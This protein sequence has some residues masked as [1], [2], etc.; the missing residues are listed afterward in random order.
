M[1]N[2]YRPS[3]NLE[4]VTPYGDLYKRRKIKESNIGPQIAWNVTTLLLRGGSPW[5]VYSGNPFK[6]LFKGL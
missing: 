4:E 2:E 3:N 6:R 5:K 1:R